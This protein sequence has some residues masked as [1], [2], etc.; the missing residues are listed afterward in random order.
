M[1]G[2][3]APLAA[4][5]LAA[6]VTLQHPPLARSEGKWQWERKEGSLLPP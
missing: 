1:R 2:A 6:L 3:A 4:V 5:L